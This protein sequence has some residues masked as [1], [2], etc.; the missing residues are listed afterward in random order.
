[1]R[2]LSESLSVLQIGGLWRPSR[3]ASLY[4]GSAYKFYTFMVTFLLHHWLI[5]GFIE[6]I[7]SYSNLEQFIADAFLTIAIIG[8]CGKTINII[9]YQKSIDKVLKILMTDPCLPRDD[10][11]MIMQNKHNRK[12]R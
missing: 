11:E 6:L 10:Y 2:I 1:M 9:M 3:S 5:T 12:I 4:F 7:R 8:T